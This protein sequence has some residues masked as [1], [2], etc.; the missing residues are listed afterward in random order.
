MKLYLLTVGL[1]L[2]MSGRMVAQNHSWQIGLKELP[3]LATY[4]SQIAGPNTSGWRF[5]LTP[6]IQVIKNL[7]KH[8][9]VESGAYYQSRGATQISVEA[10][11][12][13]APGASIPEPTSS[14]HGAYASYIS[15]PLM[16]RG[17][18]KS[19]YLAAGLSM[20]RLISYTS[21]YASYS[22]KNY[23]I[24]APVSVGYT[25]R[26]L[27]K[28][29]IFAEARWSSTVSSIFEKEFI[30]ATNYGLGVGINYSLARQKD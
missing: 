13:N 10:T 1:L 15:I 20:D 14:K 30:K 4:H 25:T 3:E 24:A 6:G 21:K 23:V 5:L 7:G 29:A 18:Y 17:H 9:S 22:Y 11:L 27:P 28:T 26:I 2:C 12:P 19:F 16:L 8:F